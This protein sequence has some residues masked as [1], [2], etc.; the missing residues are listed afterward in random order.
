MAASWIAVG[1]VA[2]YFLAAAVRC[3]G[4]AVFGARLGC[5]LGQHHIAILHDDHDGIGGEGVVGP[6]KVDGLPNR[7]SCR[8]CVR[9]GL[10]CRDFLL[11]SSLLSG[12]C[13]RFEIGNSRSGGVMLKVKSAVLDCL[14]SSVTATVSTVGEDVMTSAPGIWTD[15]PLIVSHTFA[16]SSVD[17]N[18]KTISLSS[19]ASVARSG[20]AGDKAVDLFRRSQTRL[21][22]WRRSRRAGSDW[23]WRRQPLHRSRRLRRGT[24]YSNTLPWEPSGS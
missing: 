5:R 4:V 3:A 24:S 6:G 8:N 22:R 16:A 23:L 20:V 12:G 1:Y 11:V 21:D 18:W 2:A 10:G 13:I 19:V 14:A 17:P 7:S 15:L 9:L